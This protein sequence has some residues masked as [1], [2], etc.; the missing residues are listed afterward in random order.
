MPDPDVEIR[1]VGKGRS[2]RPLD[3]GGG[4]GGPN[5]FFGPCWPQFGPKRRG[6]GGPPGGGGGTPRGG[7]GGGG[8]GRSP[9]IFFGPSGLSLV[10]K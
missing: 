4:G 3:R 5:N 7:G 6:G 2:S 1:G 8:G 9:T 10:Q